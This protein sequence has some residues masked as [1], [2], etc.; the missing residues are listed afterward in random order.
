MLATHSTDGSFFSLVL[1][2]PTLLL[3][4]EVMLHVCTT[5]STD[6]SGSARLSLNLHGAINDGHVDWRLLVYRER[7]PMFLH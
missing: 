6:S 4:L 5:T 7:L 2:G 1:F 3:A